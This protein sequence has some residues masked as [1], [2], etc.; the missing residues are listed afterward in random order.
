MSHFSVLVKIP[1]DSLDLREDDPEQA[2]AEMLDLYDEN[3]S[4]E[5][6]R[7]SMDPDDIKRMV[8]FYQERVEEKAAKAGKKKPSTFATASGGW[9][10]DQV[11]TFVD[12]CYVID[13]ETSITRDRLQKLF[14]THLDDWGSCEGG[15]DDAGPFEMST[16]NPRAKWDWW[17]IGGRWRGGL[18]M[19]E[20]VA[21]ALG[22]PGTFE[23]L[24]IDDGKETGTRDPCLT[25]VCKVKDLDMVGMGLAAAEEI[26]ELFESY[27]L[28]KVAA[29]KPEEKRS[30]AEQQVMRPFGLLSTMFDMGIVKREKIGEDGNG[31][32]QFGPLIFE[33]IPDLETFKKRYHGWAGFSTWAVVDSDGW[34]DKGDMG[35]FGCHRGTADQFNEFQNNFLDA[36]IKAEDPETTLVLVDCH[37]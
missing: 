5:P 11:G 19:K 17:V 3:K 36:F 10:S 15:I 6:Y 24:A 14:D 34:H 16:Y 25:D 27:H 1:A 35:W 21:Q 32:P 8:A 30:L 33:E 2:V 13:Q 26:K 22:Q 7:E 31:R 20:G 37:I 9:R 28:V 23:A 4:L 29:G 12:G 18:R